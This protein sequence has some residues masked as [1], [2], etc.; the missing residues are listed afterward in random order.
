MKPLFSILT[1]SYNNGEYLNDWAKSILQQTYRP[2]EVIFIDDHCTDITDDK[3]PQIKNR[4]EE[5]DISLRVHRNPTRLHYGTC[6]KLAWQNASGDYYGFLDSDDMLVAGSVD[7]IVDLYQRKPEVSYIYTQFRI[8]NLAMIEQKA[9]WSS[10]PET[11][12]CLLDMGKIKKHGFSH[13]RTF[14]KRFPRPEKLWKDGLRC[15]VDKYLGY[16]LEEFGTGMFANR[17]CYNYRWGNKKAI[18]KTE[19]SIE[20]WRHII[21]EADTR[22]KKYGIKPYPILTHKD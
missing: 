16:R 3:L 19:K 2:L 14:S 22:R 10:A 15:A 20:T 18:S 6:C 9:G 4:F 7:Y 11:G 12:K 1:S 8:C 17:I 21:A 13:W 5:A